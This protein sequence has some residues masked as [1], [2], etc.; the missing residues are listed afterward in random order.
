MKNKMFSRK[1]MVEL[2]SKHGWSCKGARKLFKSYGWNWP[3][4]WKILSLKNE[5]D[6]YI[7]EAKKRRLNDG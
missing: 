1:D 4:I 6:Y 2:F 7:N 5:P 3:M